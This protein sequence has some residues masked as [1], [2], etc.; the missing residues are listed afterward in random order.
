MS[1]DAGNFYKIDSLGKQT[2]YASPPRR[3]LITVL[4]AFRNVNIFVFYR[5]YQVYYYYDRFL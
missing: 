2:A 4:E 3:G 5:E 1:D